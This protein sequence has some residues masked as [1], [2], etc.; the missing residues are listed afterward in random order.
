[1]YTDTSVMAV[2]G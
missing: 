1:M 2:M